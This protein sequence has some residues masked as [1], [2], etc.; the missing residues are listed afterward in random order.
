MMLH[1]ILNIDSQL[2]HSS[3]IKHNSAYALLND[4]FVAVRRQVPE[5]HVLCATCRKHTVTMP[6]IVDGASAPIIPD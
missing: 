2:Q 1:N 6:A 4:Q 5:Q 3:L